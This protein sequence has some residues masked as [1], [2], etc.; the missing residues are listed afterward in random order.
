MRKLVIGEFL[1]LDG[2]MEAPERWT[3]PSFNEEVGA[4]LGSSRAT[5][6]ALLLGCV[7]YEG[8]APT[9]SHQTGGEADAMNHL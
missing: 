1:S 8:F 4:H 9:F 5:S 2:I 3:F 7:T 6:D